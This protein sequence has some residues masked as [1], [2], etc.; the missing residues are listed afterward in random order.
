MSCFGCCED[1]D[2]HKATDHGGPYMVKNPAGNLLCYAIVESTN[3]YLIVSF[4]LQILFLLLHFFL[5]LFVFVTDFINLT[6]SN[7][8]TQ[9]VR[10][11][12]TPQELHL[13]VLKL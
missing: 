3:Y 13:G 4:F 9:E 8:I 6:E 12:I 7:F 5:C 1:D 2:M 11:A 10:E